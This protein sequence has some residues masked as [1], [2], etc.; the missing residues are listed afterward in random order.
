M[1]KICIGIFMIVLDCENRGNFSVVFFL[2]WCVYVW[3]VLFYFMYILC[4][5]D[6]FWFVFFDDEFVGDRF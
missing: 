5:I 3:C 1:V 4:M 6:F 2:L